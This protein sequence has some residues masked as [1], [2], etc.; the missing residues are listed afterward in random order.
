MFQVFEVKQILHAIDGFLESICSKTPKT[1]SKLTDQKGKY[2]ENKIVDIFKKF[3]GSKCLVYTSYYVNGCEQD[4]LILWKDNAF[5]IEAKGYKLREPLRDPA[6]AFRRIKDDFKDSI[7]YGYKQTKRVEEKFVNQEILKIEDKNGHVLEEIDT[8]KYKDGDFSIIVNLQ[9]FGQIQTD[10]STLLEI[11]EEDLYPWVV[12][13]DDL[14][15]FILTL[16]AKRKRPQYLIDFLMM[17]ED[18]HGKLL[19]SDELEVCGGYLLNILNEKVVNESK[20]VIT[21]PDLPTIFDDQ[22]HKEMGFKKEKLLVEKR[23]KKY[24]FWG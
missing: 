15:V 13:L 10:L 14:E 3:F 9:S 21:T 20:R 19:C 22:Y 12:K 6:R 18:L 17:R 8:T 4:I 7:G 16:I 23:S 2:L 24:R 1:T 5:I 11:A